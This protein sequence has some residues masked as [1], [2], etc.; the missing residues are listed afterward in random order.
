[1]INKLLLGLMFF[2]VIASGSGCSH[3]VPPIANLEEATGNTVVC[4]GDSITS[5]S[6]ALPGYDYPSTL[7]SL[8]SLEVI[9]A[10]VSGDTTAQALLR[11]DSD[12]VAKHPRFAVVELGGNDYLQQIPR[13]ITFSNLRQ[14][15]D[16]IEK[17]KTIV[18]LVSMPLG[19]DYEEEYR[20][21]AL[22]NGCVLVDGI[23]DEIYNDYTLM[24]DE[25]HPN[26][27][28]YNMLAVRV[29]D[30]IDSLETFESTGKSPK[31]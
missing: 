15:V 6:G 27:K 20:Q 23:M 10:G 30:V 28:G 3:A 21:L 18:L 17:G 2:S 22:E 19:A 25:V 8:S 14:I 26:S 11:V 31:P 13:K 5:G 4:F 12:V 1:M 7:L 24:S 16:R 29:D 9:N